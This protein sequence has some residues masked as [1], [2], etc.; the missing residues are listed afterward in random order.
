MRKQYRAALVGCSRMG[1]FIDN[2]LAGRRADFPHSHAAGYEACSRTDLVAGSDLRRDVLVVYG[3]RYRVSNE[4]L[5]TDYKELIEKEKP[6][7]LSIATQPEQRAEIAIFAAKHGVKALY[8][9]KAMC[10]SLAEADAMVEAVEDHDLAFNMGTNRRWEPGFD[11]MREM[12]ASGQLGA[13]K[14]LIIYNNDTLFNTS[15]HTFDLMQRLNGD[16]PATWVQ[17]YLPEG[18]E[19]LI[20]DELRDDPI[21]E[22]AFGFA[23]GVTAYAMSSPRRNECEAVC[24]RGVLTALN[25][26]D[27]FRMREV[28]ET[29]VSS[30][31]VDSTFPEYEEA[32]STLRLIDDLVAALDRG[33]SQTRDGVRVARANMELIF[34]LIE[35]HRRDS[36][37]IALPLPDPSIRLIRYGRKARQPLYAPANP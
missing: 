36:A 26:G 4:H 15:S 17:G 3:Q 12:I 1:A 19:L 25:D 27:E 5:Y 37:R 11:A 33:D 28:R 32:S 34:G 30:A 24:E 18:R 8:C 13:L 29:G 14:T 31:L 23:N 16:V 21:G 7:I 35:S 2:E 20:G 22:G 10:A 6:D 9:E